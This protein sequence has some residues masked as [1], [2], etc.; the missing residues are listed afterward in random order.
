MFENKICL[1]TGAAQGIGRAI[2]ERFAQNGAEKVYALDMNSD[3]LAA[4][5][6]DIENVEAVT[7]NICD[8]Q[9]IAELVESIKQQYSR[10]DVLVNN[11]GV[12]RDALIDKMTEQE[13]DFVLDVNLKGV[14]NLTQAIAPLMMEN[15]YGSIVTMSSVVGT[16][17]NIGQTNYA[18]TKGGVIAMTKGWAKEFARKGAQVRANCVAPGFIETPMTAD[19]PEKVLDMMKGKTPL[20]RMG[21]TEDIT[22]GVEFLASDKS[23]FITGQVLKIDGGLVL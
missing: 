6:S 1:V 20:G 3:G 10:V 15:N 18:A 17:G 2:T 12:T 19:L 8:R 11:A 7:V 22:N 13:W 16:D 23:S 21:T 4:A 9:A 5:F 14:F